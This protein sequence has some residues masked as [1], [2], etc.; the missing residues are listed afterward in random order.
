MTHAAES[1]G[2]TS[3]AGRALIVL[4]T[5]SDVSFVL[6]DRGDRGDRGDREDKRKELQLMPCR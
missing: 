1:I 2:L 4:I 5:W 3:S 6:L